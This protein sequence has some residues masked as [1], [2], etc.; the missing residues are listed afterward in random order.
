MNGDFFVNIEGIKI[1]ECERNCDERGWVFEFFRQDELTEDIY[2]VMA[3]ATVTRPNTSRG[4]HEHRQMTENI[5]FTGKV[6]YKLY[7]WDNRMESLT[8]NQDTTLLIPEGKIVNLVIPAG[9]VFAYK[10]IGRKDGLVFNCPNKLFKGKGYRDEEDT[11]R[12][13]SNP[14]SPYKIDG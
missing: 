13:E 10:N 3:T 12:H 14:N 9:V 11:I 7:F 2:P 8:Y 1:K 6:P 5:T 4:P